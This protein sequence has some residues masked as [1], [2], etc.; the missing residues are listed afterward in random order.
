MPY[1][2]MATDRYV[3]IDYDRMRKYR[4]KR[5]QEQMKKDSID[6]L[7]TWDPYSIRYTTGAYVTVPNR[8]A[9]A[10]CAIIPVEGDPWAF[11]LASFDP[12]ALQGQMPW[13]KGKVQSALGSIKFA[14]KIQELPK[15]VNAI[16]NILAENNMSKDIMVGLDGC[17]GELLFAEL[18]NS[19]GI[20]NYCNATDTM[21][22][23]RAIKN[24]DEIACLRYSCHMADAAFADIADAI[25]PGIRECDLVGIGM[26]K[27]Y[28][29]GADE[30]LE[31][32]CAS[33]PRTNPLFID[34]TDRAIAPGELICVDINGASFQGYKTCYYR[35]F[36]CGKASQ[37]QKDAYKR[38]HDEMYAA[39]EKIKPG[40][41]TSEIVSVWPTDS[42]EFGYSSWQHCRGFYLGHGLGLGLQE[43][44]KM[45]WNWNY[46]ENEVLQ[47]GMV[48]AMETYY[49]PKGAGYGIRLEEDIVVTKDGYE[50]L[51]KFP[52]DGIVECWRR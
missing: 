20:K 21:F 11:V 48:L 31:F 2:T 46:G 36:S 14:N 35:T 19:I 51:T 10:Q 5:T 42:K 47:E 8:Y 41:T 16:E 9:S 45:F 13:M 4:L 32:V 43:G 18:L 22:L 15:Y 30:C 39:I 7:I 3:G 40:V 24:Q 26:K 37:G 1:G 12:F 23:A 27:L 44:P 38:C 49:G 28:E 34:F 50:L 17:G 25:R 6:L 29:M 33:G 52:V